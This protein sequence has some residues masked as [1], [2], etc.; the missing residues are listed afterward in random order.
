MITL[1]HG[2]G[3]TRSLPYANR[4]R[5][6]GADQPYVWLSAGWRDFLAAPAASLAYGLIFVVIGLALTFG[7]SRTEKIYMLLPLASGFMLLV[8]LVSLG[9]HAMSRDIENRQRPSFLEALTAW[10]DNAG[11]IVNAALA[12]MFVF[13]LWIRLSEILFALTFPPM[14]AL[15]FYGLL[16]A[17]F[18]TAGGV[19][20]LVLFLA[21]GASLAA[22]TFLGGVFALPILLDRDVSMGEAVAISFTACI[23]NPRAMAVWAGMTILLIAAGMAFAFLG[24]AVTLPLV[25]YASWHAYRA[26]IAR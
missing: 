7:L 24:L 20:F 9:L 16:K 11:S 18:Q 25:G 10:R 19:E 4:I 26:V 15:S 8:P 23:M 12:L 6:V 17:T 21:L 3:S 14:A 2:G 13:L 5:V 22:L 1:T